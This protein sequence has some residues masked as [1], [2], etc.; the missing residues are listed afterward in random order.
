MAK[1]SSKTAKKMKVGSSQFW[2]LCRQVREGRLEATRLDGDIKDAQTVV[3]EA[4]LSPSGK[5]LGKSLENDDAG[6]KVTV[7]QKE[8]E[9]WDPDGVW[10]ALTPRER[11]LAFDREYDFSA[12]TPERRAELHKAMIASLSPAEKRMCV[13]NR[14]NVSRMSQAVQADKIDA[15]KIAPFME[16]KYANPYITVTPHGA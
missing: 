3:A 9:V 11:P 12:L 8:T 6:L 13:R 2:A 16:V 10:G 14:L 1:K 4:M 7:T 15:E 5:K